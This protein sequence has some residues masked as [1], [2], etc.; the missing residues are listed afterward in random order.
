[1]KSIA[2]SIMV[3]TSL[4]LTSVADDPITRW[5]NAVLTVFFF[6]HFVKESK[7]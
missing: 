7:Q 3:S 4:V 1:M 5:A 6:F 2:Y